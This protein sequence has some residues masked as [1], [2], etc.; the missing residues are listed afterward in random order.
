MLP[1]EYLKFIIKDATK[2][3]S[4]EMEAKVTSKQR[5]GELNGK[6]DPQGSNE[7]SA[8]L[9]K[10][11]CCFIP[12]LLQGKIAKSAIKN[13]RWLCGEEHFLWEDLS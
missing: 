12:C 8:T 3:D 11:F 4:T 10:S 13:L 7:T 5:K 9:C 6:D 2:D 1:K